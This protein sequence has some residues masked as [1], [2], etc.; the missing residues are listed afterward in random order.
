MWGQDCRSDGGVAGLARSTS[1]AELGS[2]PTA[3]RRRSAETHAANALRLVNQ[4]LGQGE[5]GRQRPL[6]R[7]GPRPHDPHRP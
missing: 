4:W 5:G 3:T 7:G 6:A 2:L 1:S